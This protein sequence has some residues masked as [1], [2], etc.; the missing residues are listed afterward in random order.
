MGATFD[1]IEEIRKKIA[2]KPEV[3]SEAIA[4]RKAVE[5]AAMKFPGAAR[6]YSAGS[7][8][9]LTVNHPVTDADAGLVLDRRAYPELGPD[10]GG[11]GPWET[12]AELRGVV[13]DEVSETYPDVEVETHKRGLLVSFSEPLEDD[14]DPTVDMILTLNREDADGLWIPNLKTGTWNASHPEKHTEVFTSGT[15]ELR[16]L[17]ARVSRIAK[18]WNCQW[19]KDDRALSSFNIQALAYE[20]ATDEDLAFEEAVAG[21]FEY[22]AE[23]LEQGLTNDPAG[24]SPPIALLLDKGTVTNRLKKAAEKLQDALLHDDDPDAVREILAGVFR[25]YVPAPAASKAAMANALRTGN[26]GVS[27][28]RAGA[29]NLGGAGLGFKTTTAY[30]GRRDG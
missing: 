12:V 29:V 18:A 13:A 26:S 9:H 14:Q 27:I 4:R 30:G 2:A 8:A 1:Q 22:A 10:G 16:V 15:K 7:V 19:D 11:E 21:W 25:D 24:V 20:F 17:R 28:S 6:T 5:A 3:L 23:E